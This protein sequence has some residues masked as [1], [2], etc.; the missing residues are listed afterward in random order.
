MQR[1]IE[2]EPQARAMYSFATGHEVEEMG[3][4]PHPAITMA[5]ASPDGLCGDAGLVEIKCCG[6]ARHIEMLS[7]SEPEDRY[8]K[9]IQFQMACT[10]RQWCDLAYF[11]PDFPEEMQLVVRRFDR[12][13]AAIKQMEAEVVAFLAEVDATVADLTARYLTREAA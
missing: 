6:P 1:G 3:F 4:A 10:G 7:G 2:L 9:Q 5:G 8:V 12:D 11:S 13:D